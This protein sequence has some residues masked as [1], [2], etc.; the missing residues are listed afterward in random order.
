MEFEPYHR[1]VAQ[2]LEPTVLRSAAAVVAPNEMLAE[3]IERVSGVKP[4]IIRLPTD[5]AALQHDGCDVAGRSDSS[6]FNIVFTGQ[7]YPSMTEP[8]KTLLAALEEPGLENVTLHL[9]GPQPKETLEEIGL[10]GR[11]I[12]HTFVHP[13]AIYAVQRSGR[14][15][16]PRAGF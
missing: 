15:S 8:Y 2:L 16:L 13:S 4:V 12:T 5:D 14:R 6:E 9:Y 7:V 11:Y 1:F 10:V 3:S